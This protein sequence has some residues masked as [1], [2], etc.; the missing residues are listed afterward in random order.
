MQREQDVIDRARLAFAAKQH[1]RTSRGRSQHV[2]ACAAYGGAVLLCVLF[3]FGCGDERPPWSG[4]PIFPPDAGGLE[5]PPDIASSLLAAQAAFA[6]QLAVE[7]GLVDAGSVSSSATS[8][9]APMR[10]TA[11]APAPR[12]TRRDDD[13]D[14][15]EPTSG[16]AK[17]AGKAGSEAPPPAAGAASAMTNASAANAG[18]GSPVTIADAGVTTTQTDA[19]DAGAPMIP[20]PAMPTTQIDASIPTTS[21]DSGTA[22]SDADADSGN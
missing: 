5:I 14:E 1:S 15:E 11:G 12:M 17:D 7:Q 21:A 16:S 3:V 8:P 18:A 20:A 13:K 9:A 22:S 4:F 6:K 2:R 10:A 19:G